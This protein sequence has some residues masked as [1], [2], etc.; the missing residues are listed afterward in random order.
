M[1]GKN[2]QGSFQ[3]API[4]SITYKMLVLITCI[5]IFITLFL[6]I[7][8]FL[9]IEFP[10]QLLM[11]LL[12]IIFVSNGLLFLYV[13]H[14]FSPAFEYEWMVFNNILIK[15]YDKKIIKHLS[16]MG[17]SISSYTGEEY[18]TNGSMVFPKKNIKGLLDIGYESTIIH[19][20]ETNLI[21]W[22]SSKE[23]E[24]HIILGPQNDEN[25][26]MYIKIKMFIR[27][28]KMSD[29]EDNRKK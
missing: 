22:I 17:L 5:S 28:L 8:L 13:L 14:I 23:D 26:D 27:N 1:M 4:A 16:T 25:N 15:H 24:A 29:V 12:L 21:I 3:W 11:L 20:V 18:L 6:A 10:V 19:V 7:S 2:E 9:Y